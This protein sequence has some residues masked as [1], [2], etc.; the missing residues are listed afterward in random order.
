MSLS[1]RRFLS[2]SASLSAL[3]MVGKAVTAKAAEQPSAVPPPKR[4][5]NEKI[6]VAVAGING[7]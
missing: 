4:G 2:Q 1:R 6:R 3:A 5:A 7:Q